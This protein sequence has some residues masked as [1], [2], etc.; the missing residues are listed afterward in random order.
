MKLQR[1]FIE[2]ENEAKINWESN[3]NSMYS[4]VNKASSNGY[5]EYRGFKMAP[6]K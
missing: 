3:G 5:G 1:S 2:N 4:I 6:G